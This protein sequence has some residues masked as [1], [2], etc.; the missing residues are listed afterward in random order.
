MPMDEIQLLKEACD[1][2]SQSSVAKKI[3]Y[4][5]TVV[6]LVLKGS[7]TGDMNKVRRV[8]R[9]RLGISHVDCPIL[10]VIENE[11]CVTEQS[12]PFSSANSHR[13]RM[14]KACMNCPFNT[15]RKK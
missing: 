15:K 1:N 13:V 8:I 10:G 6:N 4:S 12:K 7:Y 3:G 11:K 9:T 2:T 14:F 5:P